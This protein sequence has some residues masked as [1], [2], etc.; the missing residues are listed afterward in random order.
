[1][2]RQNLHTHSEW[3]DGVNTLEEMAL[4]ASA[5]GLTSLGFSI[6]TPMPY[7][8][9]WG[10]TIAPE[11]LPDYIAEVRRLKDELKGRISIYCG[12]EWEILSQV[13]LDAF[14]YVIGSI[15]HISCNG[16]DYTVDAAASA[17]RRCLTEAFA[18]DSD[19]AAEAYFSQYEALAKVAKVDIV[20]HFDLLTK[21]DETE[22]FYNADSPRFRAA[23]LGAMDALVAA[24]KIFEI[25]T[26]AISRGYRTLPYPSRALLLELA[27]RKAKV[28]VSADAHAASDVAFGFAEAEALAIDCGFTEVWQFDGRGFVPIPIG[29]GG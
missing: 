12:A 4:A 6:H 22:H 1:M 17:T 28:T 13:S 11:R 24:D 29:G 23:A 7:E 20:G 21:F 15:H 3:D 27:R 16:T 26:G 5:A 14:E 25:N 18:G 10:W 9:G 2:I 19:V 8:D